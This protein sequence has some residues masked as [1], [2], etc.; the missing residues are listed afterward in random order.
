MSSVSTVVTRRGDAESSS[1]EHRSMVGWCECDG[2]ETPSSAPALRHRRDTG[3]K[4]AGHFLFCMSPVSRCK[5]H[6]AY[7]IV[8]QANK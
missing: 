5:V 3:N 6:G 1:S 4:Q 8:E 7:E 2:V